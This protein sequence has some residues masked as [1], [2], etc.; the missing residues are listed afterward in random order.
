MPPP[1]RPWHS[2][3]GGGCRHQREVFAELRFQRLREPAG[4][5]HFRVPCALS[6]LP[7]KLTAVH[8]RTVA[9]ELSF[10]CRF[11]PL[12]MKTAD[13]SPLE[14]SPINSTRAITNFTCSCARTFVF[15][16]STSSMPSES[17]SPHPCRRSPVDRSVCV[18]AGSGWCFRSGPGTRKK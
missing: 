7:E 9:G 5:H 16:P 15:K 11:N 17:G 4:N 13:F 3:T 2:R 18:R 8:R 10:F 1:L 12:P 6:I 14:R